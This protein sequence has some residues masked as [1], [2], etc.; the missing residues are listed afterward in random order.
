[1]SKDEIQYRLKRLRN[2]L[3]EY[4]TYDDINNIYGILEDM[5]LL[6]KELEE[7]RLNE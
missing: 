4:T 5:Y 7:E 3:H 1:M 2:K 6:I